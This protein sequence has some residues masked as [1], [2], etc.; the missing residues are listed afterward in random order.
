MRWLLPSTK[1]GHGSTTP[2]LATNHDDSV[3]HLMQ[4]LGSEDSS[5]QT[6]MSRTQTEVLDSGSASGSCDNQQEEKDPAQLE[7]LCHSGSD[8]EICS[9][10]S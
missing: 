9:E 2:R 4:T 6:T 7:E 5:S 10:K 3:I 8:H 1:N